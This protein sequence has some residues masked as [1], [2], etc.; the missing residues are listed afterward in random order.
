MQC[1]TPHPTSWIECNGFV[2]MC[3]FRVCSFGQISSLELESKAT[4]AQ[5][6][7][8]SEQNDNA[9][10]HYHPSKLE[11]SAEGSTF[12]VPSHVREYV[13]GPGTDFGGLFLL[14]DINMKLWATLG[15]LHWWFVDLNAWL[16]KAKGKALR[17]SKL[18]GPKPP[19]SKARQ[20][21]RRATRGI[22]MYWVV[23]STC[24]Q[25]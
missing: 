16:S 25:K 17:S 6:E 5:P 4:G 23:K 2:S 15:G 20:W 21:L 8:F 22:V 14:K 10:R 11:P 1:F 7:E 24:H 12:E 13:P 3:F 18:P 19:K 9:K